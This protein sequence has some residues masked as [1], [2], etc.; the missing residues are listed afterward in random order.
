M[1]LFQ[2]PAARAAASATVA[3]IM[4]GMLGVVAPLVDAVWTAVLLG[5]RLTVTPAE[6]GA[7]A[8]SSVGTAQ[9]G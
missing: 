2:R 7:M 1:L 9:H 6:E 4:P 8:E 3:S 5:L